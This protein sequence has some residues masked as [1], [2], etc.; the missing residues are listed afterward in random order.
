MA[1][2]VG[3][4]EYAVEVN[5]EHEEPMAEVVMIYDGSID[6]QFFL[7]LEDLRVF[8]GQLQAAE[9]EISEHRWH[10]E[11]RPGQPRD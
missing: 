11:N 1:V 2:D 10:I 7:P 3:E 9:R 5:E 6:Y 8:I 4:L